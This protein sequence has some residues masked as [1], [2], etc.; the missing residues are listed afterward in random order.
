M[1]L[2]NT[3]SPSGGDDGSAKD[4][5]ATRHKRG[6]VGFD[7]WLK[8]KLHEV[9]DPVLQERVPDDLL[10]LLAAFDSRKKPDGADG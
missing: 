7:L 8:M 5:K 9:Y 4:P 2:R 6:E 3:L 10:H 1:K